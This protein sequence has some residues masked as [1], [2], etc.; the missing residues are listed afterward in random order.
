MQEHLESQNLYF[1][2]LAMMLVQLATEQYVDQSNIVKATRILQQF[3][4]QVNN[5]RLALVNTYESEKKQNLALLAIYTAKC[6]Q[7]A[8]SVVVGY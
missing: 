1:Q 7:L 6:E 2:P 5:S 4:D 3:R 8:N